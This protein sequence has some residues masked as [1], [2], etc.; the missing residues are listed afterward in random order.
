MGIL[1]APAPCCRH[2]LRP[3]RTVPGPEVPLTKPQHLVPWEV[4]WFGER[5][6]GPEAGW[7]LFLTPPPRGHSFAGGSGQW[8]LSGGLQLSVP[9]TSGCRAENETGDHRKTTQHP[10]E[11]TAT[12]PEGQRQTQGRGPGA[13]AESTGGCGWGPGQRSQGQGQGRGCPH[14]L[15]RGTSRQVVICQLDLEPR[16]W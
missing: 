5:R 15:L 13:A 16:I 14:F 7:Y 10:G 12:R 1:P 11:G 6:E 2:T 4:V 8:T 3:E 9:T